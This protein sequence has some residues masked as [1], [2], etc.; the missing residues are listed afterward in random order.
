[1]V[2]NINLLEFSV[3]KLNTDSSLIIESFDKSEIVVNE[4]V[5]DC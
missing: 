5:N 4:N 1:M 3:K 2:A